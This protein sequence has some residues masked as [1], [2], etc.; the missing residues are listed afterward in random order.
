MR[1]HI[2]NEFF[3]AKN[4]IE[5][6]TRLNVLFQENL[7]TIGF[8]SAGGIAYGYNGFV[9]DLMGLNNTL[10]AHADREKNGPKGHQ[11]FNKSVFYTLAPDILMPRAVPTDNRINFSQIQA[12]YTNTNSWDNL[13]FKNIFNDEVL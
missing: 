5:N 1:M 2:S 4:E 7:P 13:I 12:Y 6:G 3:I 8:G 11:S 10:M 9:Y